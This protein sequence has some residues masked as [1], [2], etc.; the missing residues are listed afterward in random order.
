[1]PRAKSKQSRMKMRRQI[2]HTK[3][4]KLLKARIKEL[5]KAK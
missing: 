2:K 5:K 1:M 3:K 4:V